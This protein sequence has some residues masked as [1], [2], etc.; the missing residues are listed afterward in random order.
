MSQTARL[1][2]LTGIP[3]TG[4]R[5]ALDRFAKNTTKKIAIISVEDQLEELAEPYIKE[6]FPLQA[7]RLTK[8]LLPRPLLRKLWADAFERQWAKADSLLGQNTN[9]LFT[10][11]LCYF[12]HLTREYLTVVDNNLLVARLRDRK[13][14]IF[15]TLI[16]D[17]YDCC[18]RLCDPSGF[19]DL[20]TTAEEAMLDAL[21]ILDWRSV[22]ILLSHALAHACHS[23][24]FLFA[25]KHPIRTFEDLLYA[26][27]PIAYLSHPISE[28]RRIW[29]D[30]DTDKSEVHRIVQEVS[31]VANRLSPHYVVIEPTTIDE[32]R[33][34][35]SQLSTRWPFTQDNRE[36]LYSP[37]VDVNNQ[38]L[39]PSGWTEDTRK[40]VTTGPLLDRFR[41][42]VEKQIDAR[43]HTL[44]EQADV[45][46]CYRPLY[47]G[48]A[49]GGV[50]EELDHQV[51]LAHSNPGTTRPAVVYNPLSD[52]TD[53]PQ[54]QLWEAALPSWRD[55]RLVQG[56]PQDFERLTEDL[57]K[58]AV[59]NID[60]V[61]Q[62]DAEAL[63]RILHSYGLQAT[64]TTAG[65]LPSGALGTSRQTRR[66]EQAVLLSQEILMYQHPYLEALQTAGTIILTSD[67]QTFYKELGVE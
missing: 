62:G 6:L 19:C 51:R 24:H 41:S 14:T 35:E 43:D 65:T 17:I 59:P 46:A 54:R 55:R 61:L 53:Y 57:I 27:K 34:I 60:K 8:F 23:K 7:S 36:L 13:E 30:A 44:V 4:I 25:V 66:G 56:A 40:T 22:E 9:V 18:H 58:N 2:V 49:S 45:I 3:G 67:M 52:G 21:D 33:F 26:N 16:D 42:A 39:F 28:P 47:R 11:H 32:Y 20:P 1:H 64:P 50:K 5:L 63:K 38:F 48:N 12:H 15:V 37:P 10:F 29:I 31:I